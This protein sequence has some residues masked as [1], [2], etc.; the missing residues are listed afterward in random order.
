MWDLDG[1][2]TNTGGSIYARGSGRKLSRTE[3]Q[4]IIL[5]NPTF[6]AQYNQ[7]M[8]DLTDPGGPLSVAD[9]RRIRGSAAAAAHLRAGCGSSRRRDTGLLFTA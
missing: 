7:L 6:H 8:C 2:L 3:Y 4:S 5:G 9:Y 1:A